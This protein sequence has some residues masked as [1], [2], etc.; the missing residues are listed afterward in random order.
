MAKKVILL[1]KEGKDTGEAVGPDEGYAAWLARQAA[2]GAAE[3]PGTFTTLGGL[4]MAG[5]DY[6]TAG[7]DDKRSF[8]EHLL[9]PEGGKEKLQAYDQDLFDKILQKNPEYT[10]EQANERLDY[11]RKHSNRYFRETAPFYRTGVSFGRRWGLGVN[12]FFG[13]PRTPSERTLADDVV[14]V[15]GGAIPVPGA[16]G[17]AKATGTVGEK[18]AAK[19]A[20][21]APLRF[22][23]N[24]AEAVTPATV[25][26]AGATAGEIAARTGVNAG[27]GVTANQGIRAYT[28]QPSVIN[29]TETPATEPLKKDDGSGD[30]AAIG[31]AGAVATVI[32][33]RYY[34]NIIK[35]TIKAPSA[36]LAKEAMEAAARPDEVRWT[37]ALGS[38]LGPIE[39]AAKKAGLASEDVQMLMDR[40]ERVTGPMAKADSDLWVA[41]RLKP[42]ADAFAQ[43]DPQEA[44][45]FWQHVTDRARIY[46]E[47]QDLKDVDKDIADATKALSTAQNSRVASNNPAAAQAKLQK[48]AEAQAELSS[49][50]REKATRL[51]DTDPNLRPMMMEESRATVQ[52]RLNQ[53]KND[54]KIQ[55]A[56]RALIKRYDDIIDVGVKEGLVSPAQAA[57]VKA[58]VRRGNY[59]LSETP[60]TKKGW[61]ESATAKASKMAEDH[62]VFPH[63]DGAIALYRGI[64]NSN[65]RKGYL[66]PDKKVKYIDKQPDWIPQPRTNNPANPFEELQFFSLR[67]RQAAAANRFMKE[68]FDAMKGSP[69]NATGRL[70]REVDRIPEKQVQYKVSSIL[71]ALDRKHAPYRNAYFDKGDLVIMEHNSRIIRDLFKFT[72]ASVVPLLNGSRQWFQTAT[73]GTLNPAWA[74]I[75][76]PWDITM[77]T[78]LRNPHMAFGPVSGFAHNVFG[79]GSFMAQQISALAK[80]VDWAAN[81]A[82]LLYVVPKSVMT[83]AIGHQLSNRWATQL[84]TKSGVIGQIAKL[85]GGEQLVRKVT[86]SMAKAYQ[87]SWVHL[88]K[89]YKVGH[90]S[91]YSDELSS[92]MRQLEKLG[93][94]M[95]MYKSAL[96]SYKAVLSVLHD[97]PKQMF[98]SQNIKLFK[99]E[100][101][102]GRQ[103]KRFVTEDFIANEARKIGG[104]LART[105]GNRAVQAAL[106]T[107]PY[108]NVALQSVRYTANRIR[109]SGLEG[110]TSLASLGTA[111]GWLYSYIANDPKAS[112]W[113]FN[114]LPQDQ[115]MQSIPIPNFVRHMRRMWGENLPSDDPSQEYFLMRVPPEMLMFT[116][117]VMHGMMALGLIDSNKMAVP[118]TIGKD[119]KQTVDQVF[120]LGMPPVLQAF[121]AAAGYKVEPSKAMIGENPF[122]E[123]RDVTYQGA[124]KDKM[125]PQSRIPHAWHDVFN[126]LFGTVAGTI[127]EAA[128]YGDIVGAR[129]GSFKE[130]LVEGAKKLAVERTA[131]IPY[132]NHIWP[133]VNRRFIY[134]PY[135][136]EHQEQMNTLRKVNAQ[137]ANEPDLH[138]KENQTENIETEGGNVGAPV[139]DEDL[140][141]LIQDVHE[142]FFTGEMVQLQKERAE[143]RKIHQS[144]TLG[145]GG[146]GQPIVSPLVKFKQAQEQAKKVNELDLEMH[147]LRQD[148]WKEMVTS[149]AGKAFEAKFGGPLTPDNLLK[150]VQQ[151]STQAGRQP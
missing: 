129:T 37:S 123:I 61:L 147:N 79:R 103:M 120:G 70:V 32:G 77:G 117:P 46:R 115:R 140:R 44:T 17:I 35:G 12:D 62:L 95:P 29:P 88:A 113:Y 94:Q 122:R 66:T 41:S 3:T 121:S 104:D 23:T 54:P 125:T 128:N 149:P 57:T 39:S 7:K 98:L 100:L 130:G 9:D 134:T 18:V 67:T 65:F 119:F 42:I 69:G 90:I 132:A 106:S 11:L 138:Y 76:V 136:Q 31:A 64:R 19:L 24:V 47:V 56:E 68:Y 141:D 116:L 72:P 14:N 101:A 83:E 8:G 102:R 1:D 75:G 13:D 114:E 2:I 93:T 131:R 108:G 63:T 36:G 45:K 55:A 16:G 52:A 43:G 51:A 109:N 82:R 38:D 48:I 33:A 21:S 135:A 25:I 126:A 85:P 10:P 80:P 118:P 6:L 99:R 59:S 111:V 110:A 60:L 144:L 137:F 22:A 74:L 97:V 96:S 150:A 146:K 34:K 133:D 91:N 84:T 86:D 151:S 4:I 87:E 20:T 53:S 89:A 58:T 124:N 148:L 50:Q 105:S 71:E 27:I 73:T 107:V 15:V 92:Q 81:M 139:Q 30:I 142:N 49:L 26:P 78:W 143:A 28:G 5:K 40:A 112:N 127:M 145:P